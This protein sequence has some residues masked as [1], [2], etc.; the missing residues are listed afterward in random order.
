MTIRL[1]RD[2]ADA[3]EMV[4]AV[5][6]QPIAEV[7]RLAINEHLVA[8]RDDHEFQQNLRDHLERARDLLGSETPEQP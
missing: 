2:Q 4:A 7:I 5:D 1:G 8:R 6:A 3:L